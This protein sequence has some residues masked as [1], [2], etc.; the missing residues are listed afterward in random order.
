MCFMKT[1]LKN[2]GAHKKFYK[3][4]EDFILRGVFI[5]L[6]DSCGNSFDLQLIFW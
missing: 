3:F 2:V 5:F 4:C 1:F 6:L